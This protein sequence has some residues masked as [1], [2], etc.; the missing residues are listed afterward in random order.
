[1]TSRSK[2]LVSGQAVPNIDMVLATGY[3]VTGTVRD[4]AGKTLAQAWVIAQYDNGHAVG[5]Q[6]DA[7]GRS[8]LRLENGNWDLLLYPPTVECCYEP[9][10]RRGITVGT[11]DLALGD[12]TIP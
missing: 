4:A 8:L 2:L 10:L 3:A 6:S 11:A 1:M 9:N 12:V 5:M 7:S